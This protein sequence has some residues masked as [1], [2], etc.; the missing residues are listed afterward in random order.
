[1]KFAVE[2][3]QSVLDGKWFLVRVEG[4]V[5]SVLFPDMEWNTKEEAERFAACFNH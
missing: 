5:R 1:M 2:V 3:A 4:M